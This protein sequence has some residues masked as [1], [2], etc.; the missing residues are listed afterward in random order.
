MTNARV[1]PVAIILANVWIAA[2]LIAIE[3]PWWV[4]MM[5]AFVYLGFAIK[6]I[7]NVDR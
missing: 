7:L 6:D 4:L 5:M 3:S 2:T 1:D